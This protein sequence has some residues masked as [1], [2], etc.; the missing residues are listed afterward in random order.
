M[1]YLELYLWSAFS[2]LMSLTKVILHFVSSCLFFYF[3]T[4]ALFPANHLFSHH[5][6]SGLPA[7][8]LFCVFICVCCSVHASPLLPSLFSSPLFSLSSI[9]KPLLVV[10]RAS[11]SRHSWDSSWTGE[12]RLA[13]LLLGCQSVQSPPHRCSLDFHVHTSDIK[14]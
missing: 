2:T 9:L 7:A 4:A 10:S 13:K 5:R 8:W 6:S 11:Y 12:R 1:H 3:S 14:V